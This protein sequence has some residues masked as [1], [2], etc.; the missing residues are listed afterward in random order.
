MHRH[1]NARLQAALLGAAGLDMP[2][3]GYSTSMNGGTP[4]HRC[5]CMLIE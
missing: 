5:V 3:R 2:L 1:Q 4:I